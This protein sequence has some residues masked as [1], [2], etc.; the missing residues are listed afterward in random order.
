MQTLDQDISTLTQCYS[1]IDLPLAVEEGADP[2][3]KIDSAVRRFGAAARR[4]TYMP[5]LQRHILGNLRHV[6]RT[7]SAQDLTELFWFLFSQKAWAKIDWLSRTFANRLPS[8]PA[9]IADLCFLAFHRMQ[10]ELLVSGQGAEAFRSA[11]VPVIA[12]LREGWPGASD[13][14]DAFGAMVEHVCGDFGAAREVFAGIGGTEFIEPFAGIASVRMPVGEPR[15]PSVQQLVIRPCEAEHVTLLSLDRTYFDKFAH[16]AATR[17]A[18]SNPRNGLHFHCVGFD[19]AEAISQWRLPIPIGLTIDSENLDT[20]DIRQKRGYFASAR[21]LHLARYLELYR[22]VFVADVD[23]HVWRDVSELDTEYDRFDVILNTKILDDTRKLTRLPWEAISAGAVMVRSTE[24][25]R[26]FAATLGCYLADVIGEGTAK[27]RPLW[28]AD[29]TALF[30]TW[31]DV[32]NSVR[33]ASFAKAAF[34]QRGSWQLFEGDRER[35]EF[36]SGG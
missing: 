23:G 9:H 10:R 5:G 35:L 33:F 13:R 19:P 24:G 2:D 4:G 1:N 28:Y 25:G 8:L 12:R 16:L 14:I 32:G 30:Y 29:Q 17:Y 22:S 34:M 31:L 15:L 7:I 6:P 18:E 21:H 3:E 27:R 26:R 36:M 20:L 11:A